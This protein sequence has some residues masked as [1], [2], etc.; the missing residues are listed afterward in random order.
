MQKT[1]DPKRIEAIFTL[2]SSARNCLLDGAL[3]AAMANL[4][5][6]LK[7][8]LNTPMLKKER[9]VLEEDFFDLE[10]K[11]AEHPKFKSTY[12]PV[13]FA[14]G[15]HKMAMDFMSQL[16]QFGAETVKE[17]IVQGKELLEAERLDEAWAVFLEVMDSP[18]AELEDF[19]AIGDAYLQ[20]NRWTEAQEVFSRAVDRDPD[21]INALNRLAISLRKDQQF[22]KALN[23]YRKALMLSPHDEGLYFNVARLF[24]DWDKPDTAGQALRKALSINPSFEPAQKLLN[25]I[26][27]R[28][29]DSDDSPEA[30]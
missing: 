22:A 3:S 5:K 6:A 19:I 16:I 11:I 15:E 29:A 30:S 21:S 26:Q 24:M 27:E 13:S 25:E 18:A 20:K 10:G 1:F 7:L 23:I 28:L 8:Y 2:V 14:R 17:K 9:E 12:G 4:V